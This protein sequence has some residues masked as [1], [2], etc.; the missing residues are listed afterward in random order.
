MVLKKIGQF[1]GNVTGTVTGEPIKFIGKALNNEYIE[2]IG[3]GVKKA[4]KQT[5]HTRVKRY[6]VAKMKCV[7]RLFMF[8]I[9]IAI[10]LILNFVSPSTAIAK[11]PEVYKSV[12]QPNE[13]FSFIATTTKGNKVKLIFRKNKVFYTTF[14]ME[15]NLDEKIVKKLTIQLDKKKTVSIKNNKFY[16]GNKLYTGKI[17]TKET[18]LYPISGKAHTYFNGKI[19]KGKIK[20]GAE[21]TVSYDATFAG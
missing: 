12:F 9:L 15:N 8:S 13:E 14:I 17:K 16:I 6:G 4:T 7:N 2:E 3:E 20:N 11:K 18:K 5:K 1:L 19:S 21:Y 10:S